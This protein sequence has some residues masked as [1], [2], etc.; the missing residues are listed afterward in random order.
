MSWRTV[1]RC[2]S[3]NRHVKDGLPCQDYGGDRVL[4]KVL[5][6]AVADGA[7]S[8]AYAEVG[9]QL[10]TTTILDYLEA[11]EQ[12]L[13]KQQSSWLT[14]PNEHVEEVAQE[15]FAKAITHILK[16][17]DQQVQANRYEMQDVA[18]TLIAFVA[19]PHSI[20]AMQI[21]DGFIVVRLKDQNYQLMFQPDKGEYANQT[22]FLTSSDALNAMKTQVVFGPQ[23]FICA[24]TDGLE[25]VALRR[26]DWTPFSPFFNPL[27]EFMAETV[28]PN[29]NDGY[30]VD[31]LTS[32]RLNQRTD[33]DKT[34]LLCMYP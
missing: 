16:K 27:E 8:A 19:T 3:G 26:S 10:A 14:L 34:V 29:Q 9:A 17:L 21:G 18:C 25:S 11:S 20:A 28:N 1:T 15:F 7:G 12:W 24:A 23:S 6:G 33:D 5:I 2:V 31:F 13:Q 30:L 22:T 32:E 4:N